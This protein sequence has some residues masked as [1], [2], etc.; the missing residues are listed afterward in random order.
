M[1]EAKRGNRPG[2]EFRAYE[3]KNREKKIKVVEQRNEK[4]NFHGRGWGKRVYHSRV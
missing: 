4:K 3:G 2:E 1:R